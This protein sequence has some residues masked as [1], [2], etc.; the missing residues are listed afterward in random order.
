VKKDEDEGD[1]TTEDNE[2]VNGTGNEEEE[3]TN[4]TKNEEENGKEREETEEDGQGKV[5]VQDGEGE[6]EEEG[7]AATATHTEHNGDNKKNEKEEEED[8]FDLSGLG[9]NNSVKSSSKTSGLDPLGGLSLG[10]TA[11]PKKE[12]SSTAPVVTFGTDS[13]FGDALGGESNPLET[14]SMFGESGTP[15]KLNLAA[16]DASRSGEIDDELFNEQCSS[17]EEKKTI[18]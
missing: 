18:K 16:G 11:S 14:V 5:V 10:F 4:V 6:E 15:K 13:L 9:D 7:D 1:K 2:Q 3:T 17:F 12:A 8:P